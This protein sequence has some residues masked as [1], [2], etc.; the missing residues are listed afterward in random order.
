VKEVAIDSA[1]DHG[2]RYNMPHSH[3]VILVCY[4]A[5]G[6]LINRQ[7]CPLTEHHYCD[8]SSRAP[9]SN[10]KLQLCVS[11]IDLYQYTAIEVGVLSTVTITVQYMY[12]YTCI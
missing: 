12:M 4:L 5:R 10:S 2:K 1:K 9:S 6:C 8:I 3:N 7:I 11:C